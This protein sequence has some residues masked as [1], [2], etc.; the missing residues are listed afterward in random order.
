MLIDGRTWC[1]IA[2]YYCPAPPSWLSAKGFITIIC[3]YAALA[4][5]PYVVSPACVPNYAVCLDAVRA[6]AFGMTYHNVMCACRAVWQDRT[7]AACAVF[8]RQLLQ[9]YQVL[10]RGACEASAP[11]A[12]VTR[13]ATLLSP[14][15]ILVLV[16]RQESDVVAN[17][18]PMSSENHLEFLQL[19]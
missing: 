15:R 14:H 5:E 6:Q 16:V 9:A 18:T 1:H 19:F 13:L 10:H 8:P 2:D 17:T 11:H 12:L 3:W 4:I 7:R